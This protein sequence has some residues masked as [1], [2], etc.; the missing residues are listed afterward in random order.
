MTG[1]SSRGHDL[2]LLGKWVGAGA[3]PQAQEK[4][5][6]QYQTKRLRGF[7]A[8]TGCGSKTFKTG[9]LQQKGPILGS[10]PSHQPVL[11]TPALKTQKPYLGSS[12]LG[13]N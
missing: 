11:S 13:Q 8:N 4:C 5:H 10:K 7:P 12:T 6:T 9:I 1:R 2:E 3:I